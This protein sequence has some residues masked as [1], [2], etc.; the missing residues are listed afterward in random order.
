MQAKDPTGCVKTSHNQDPKRNI[1][2]VWDLHFWYAS[3]SATMPCPEHRRGN[4][5]ALQSRWQTSKRAP[6][7][8]ATLRLC[9]QW[10][11]AATD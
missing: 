4:E 9:R 7:K 10:P 6:Y 3:L 1:G 5:T 11:R 8:A 2:E